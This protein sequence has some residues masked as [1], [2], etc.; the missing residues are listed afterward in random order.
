MV[1]KILLPVEGGRIFALL[2]EYKRKSGT[3][4]GVVGE[5]AGKVGWL[6]MFMGEYQHSLDDKSRI[7][8][9]AKFRE[10]LGSSFVMTRGLDACLFVYPRDDWNI[11]EQKLRSMPLSRSD[12][13]QFI[14]FFFSG[15]A[16]LDLDKQG[17]VLIPATLR[18]YAGITQDCVV[19]GV[20]ARVEIWDAVK[21]KSYSEVAAGSFNDLAQ[22]L[23]DLD[24]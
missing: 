4:W 14:R 23:V 17:R 12:A 9:P 13:R 1:K 21:W 18:D 16:E 5:N 8:I 6:I 24:F 7:T 10:G 2:T 3:K 20:G 22:G 15:A 19:I 11:M